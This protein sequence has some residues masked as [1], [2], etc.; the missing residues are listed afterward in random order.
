MT[1]FVFDRPPRAP[2]SAV[3]LLGLWAAVLLRWRLF[4]ADPLVVALLLALTLPAALDYATGR[5]AGLRLDD[6][7]LTWHSGR[8][9]AEVA[10]A[11]IHC[12]RFERR[13]DLTMRVRVVTDAGKRIK[14]PQ[15]ALPPPAQFETALTARGIKVEQHPFSL[16]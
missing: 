3:I 10:L 11:R 13:L 7:W 1:P 6:R 5:R 12:M 2:A 8:Q 16:L 9:E 15:D 4:E 14:I